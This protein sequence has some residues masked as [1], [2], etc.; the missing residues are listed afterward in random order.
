MSALNDYFQ[1]LANKIRSYTKES[2]SLTPNNMI[3]KL[4]TIYQKGFDSVD[5]RNQLKY[6][7]D[8][9]LFDWWTTDH[10]SSLTGIH[11]SDIWTDGT[12]IYLSTPDIGQYK[13]S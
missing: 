5:A 9:A 8:W 13:S 2:G 7:P 3:G 10:A 4:D 6:I 1:A 12:N 11:G